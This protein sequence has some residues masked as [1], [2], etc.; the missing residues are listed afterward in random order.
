MKLA[1]KWVTKPIELLL[2]TEA[3]R[4]TKFISPTEV[5]SVQRVGKI[6]RRDKSIVLAVKLGKPNYEERE[7]IAKC[8]KVGEKFPV[9]KIQLK[10]P[11]KQRK[12]KK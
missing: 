5:V 4:A 3:K 9:S 1:L 2:R 11:P 12:G 7:F 6:D 10:F 8:I